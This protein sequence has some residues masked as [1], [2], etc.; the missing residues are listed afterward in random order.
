M[1]AVEVACLRRSRRRHVIL[2]TNMLTGRSP[3]ACHPHYFSA[4]SATSCYSS[5]LD[6]IR[7]HEHLLVGSQFWTELF[8]NRL[9]A[10]LMF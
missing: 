10:Q 7:E 9:P 6:P 1:A 3:K 4:S 8:G 5:W 2:V